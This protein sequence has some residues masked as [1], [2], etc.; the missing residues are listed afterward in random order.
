[1]RYFLFL[2]MLTTTAYAQDTSIF[3]GA[4]NSGLSVTA[5]PR[6][7]FAAELIVYDS[8]RIIGY[9]KKDSTLVIIGDSARFIRIL[10]ESMSWNGAF[11]VRYPKRDIVKWKPYYQKKT[12][13]PHNT[14]SL[15]RWGG[16][17]QRSG[18]LYPDGDTAWFM[19]Y[20]KRHPK[21]FA[22]MDKHNDSMDHVQLGGLITKDTKISSDSL[23]NGLRFLGGKLSYDTTDSVKN[24]ITSTH[25]IRDTLFSAKGF[26]VWEP[27]EFYP[28][29]KKALFFVAG[30]IMTVLAFVA[31]EGFR[32]KE[33]GIDP[34]D[35]R[36]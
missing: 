27:T 16:P 6:E 33:V 23:G 7:T 8:N 1:M 29:W 34:I 30:I 28:W 19:D 10:V 20:Q 26:R 22:A 31:I 5:V 13:H 25:W 21:E 2:L 17:L 35:R 24:A 9:Q 4:L 15:P 36:N 3:N 32:A 12:H 18:I 14:A 11:K